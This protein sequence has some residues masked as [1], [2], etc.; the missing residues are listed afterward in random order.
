MKKMRRTPAVAASE[1]SYR[2]HPG[3]ASQR[4]RP[5]V[6][7][8]HRVVGVPSQYRP[9]E[10]PKIVDMPMLRFRLATM[11]QNAR[12]YTARAEGASDVNIMAGLERKAPQAADR[13]LRSSGASENERIRPGIRFH[14]NYRRLAPSAAVRSRNTQPEPL[15]CPN[16]Q[17]KAYRGGLLGRSPEAHLIDFALKGRPAAK[18][19]AGRHDLGLCHTVH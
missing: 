17:I 13:S 14:F 3:H 15:P 5:A 7:E 2:G 9:H 8:V 12:G 10:T 4:L 11:P 18:K 19:A 16:R 6:L 1:T